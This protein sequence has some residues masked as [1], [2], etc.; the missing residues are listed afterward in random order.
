MAAMSAV[1]SLTV[2]GDKSLS[3][4]ALM[5]AALGTGESVLRGVLPSA[6]VRNTAGVLQALGV[7]VPTAWG[8]DEVLRIRGLGRRGLRAPSRT[9]DCGN[10]GTTTRL[11]AGVVA[12]H[13]LSGTF[14]GDA[15]LSR[16][17][18]RRVARPLTAMGATFSFDGDDGLP[19]TVRGGDLQPID[20]VSPTASAQVKSAILLAALVAGVSARVQEPTR[21]RDHTER[22]LAALGAPVI[23][24]E[25]A[26]LLDPVDQLAPLHFEVP[27]DPSS[28]LFMIASAVL[29]G[30]PLEVRNVGIN[31][32]RRGA[33]PVLQRMGV[34]ITFAN[35]REAGGE[36]V[37]D[38]HVAPSGGLHG[39]EIGAAEVPSL[40]DEI[41]VLACLAACATGETRI[42]G[43]AELRVKESDR[44]TA[45]VS[46]LRAIGADADELPDGMVIHGGAWTLSGA[47][48]T[49]ADHRIAMAFGV[50][51][52]LGANAIRV[53]DPACVDV[54]FPGFWEALSAIGGAR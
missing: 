25:D 16:R 36:P 34:A 23:V 53:D 20:W 2:P 38:I 35:E 18:M 24:T 5:F 44:I 27:G 54:S 50:L 39:V 37:A 19:M 47:I 22:M 4:R 45:V 51:G 33:F 40:I 10:S 30:L 9:L 6:D 28:A 42:T 31:A 48:V 52:A 46:N 41:P 13:P 1:R 43:A 17:P 8:T 32:T 3:H 7:D 14:V 11:M 49:H 15:S 12:G 26:V 21:S 29:R